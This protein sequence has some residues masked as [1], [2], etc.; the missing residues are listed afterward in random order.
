MHNCSI[1]IANQGI[2]NSVGWK[3]TE[4]ISGS[5][6]IVSNPIDEFVFPGEFEENKNYLAYG[7]VEECLEKVEKLLSDKEFRY[8][9]M[10][11]KLFVL[12]GLCPS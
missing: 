7:N 9:M 5:C 1:G 12:F 3:F 10:Q 8:E 11:K 4:Y 2:Y 6:A